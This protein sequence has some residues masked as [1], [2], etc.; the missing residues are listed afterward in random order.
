MI[1]EVFDASSTIFSSV[2]FA[3]NPYLLHKGTLYAQTWEVVITI[4]VKPEIITS[5]L[6]HMLILEPKHNKNLAL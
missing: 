1:K 2:L 4:T 3:R 5:K 6:A